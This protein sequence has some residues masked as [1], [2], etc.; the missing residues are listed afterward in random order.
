M[1]SVTRSLPTGRLGDADTVVRADGET[2]VVRALPSA[3]DGSFVGPIEA[4]SAERRSALR[5]ARRELSAERVRSIPRSWGRLRVA[6]WLCPDLVAVTAAASF[7]QTTRFGSESPA[8]NVAQTA[9]RSTLT[10][11]QVSLGLVVAWLLMVGTVRGRQRR[12][13]VSSW[14]QSVNVLRAAV[15]LLAVIGVAELFVRIRLSRSCVLAALASVVGLTFVGR[16][17]V[18]LLFSLL[19]RVGIGVD[20]LLL[21]GPHHEVEAIRSQ[22]AR[23]SGRRTRIVAVPVVDTDVALSGP[24]T[25]RESILQTIQRHGVTSVVECGPASLPVGTVRLMSTRLSGTGVNVVVPQGTTEAG[26]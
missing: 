17:V 24:S 3:A 22:L 1:C 14:D 10:Y 15:A 11:V 18:A 12:R 20:R 21:V 26:T 4:P 8:S 19:K 23:T 13:N 16:F 7:A 25:V 9:R 2:G 5:E 6:M